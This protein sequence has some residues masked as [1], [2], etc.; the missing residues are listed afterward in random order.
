MSSEHAQRKFFAVGCISAALGVVAGAFGAHGLKNMIAPDMLAVFE[1]A[2]RYQMYHAFGLIATGLIS[3]R[4]HTSRLELAG[5]CFIA[6]VIL[7]SGSLYALA[8]TEIRWLGAITPFG[9]IAFI[10]GWFFLG[11]SHFRQLPTTA[12]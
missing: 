9:G 6:G 7:F 2:V 3:N 11:W 4:T 12:R 5:W 1:T 8:L 10:A